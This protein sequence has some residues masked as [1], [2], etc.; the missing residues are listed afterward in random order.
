MATKVIQRAKPI[1]VEVNGTAKFS[2]SGIDG[3]IPYTSGNITVTTDLGMVMV[4]NLPV[5]EGTPI[6]LPFIIPDGSSGGSITCSGG[7]SGILAA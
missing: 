2:G 3:F 4:N 6:P 5:T 7:A 1:Q